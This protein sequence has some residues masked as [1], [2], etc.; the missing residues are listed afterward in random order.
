MVKNASTFENAMN[1]T[2]LICEAWDKG[3]IS[4]EIIA[5]QVASLVSSK[6]GVRGFFAISMS[7]D[8]PLL[9]RLP[10]PLVIALRLAGKVVVEVAAKNL[11]MSSAMAVHHERQGD[12]KLK[13]GSE[14]V[15]SRCIELLRHLDPYAVK[16]RLEKLL[17]G[18]RGEGEDAAF[19]IKWNYDCSQKNAILLNINLV[20]QE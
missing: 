9:D 10:E 14:R 15:S 5:D 17:D 16:E 7:I 20:A 19:L 6:E 13:I 8:C 2:I 3:V 1:K 12:E 4:D 18:L 11:A